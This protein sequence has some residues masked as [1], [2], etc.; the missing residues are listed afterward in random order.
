M[1]RLEGFISRNQ[2]LCLA[3]GLRG[4]ERDYFR[5]VID[6]LAGVI[7]A[8]PHSYQTDGQG[9]QA[10]AHLHYFTGG[11]DWWITEKDKGAEGDTPE[12]FQSQAFGLTDIGHGPELGYINIHELLSVNAE[13]DFHWTP[14]TLAEIKAKDQPDESPAEPQPRKENMTREPVPQVAVLTWA[15]E[16]VP[17]LEMVPERQW[18]WCVTN[19]Q[20]EAN[21]AARETIKAAGFKFAK[22]GH[23][24]PDG[25]IAYWAHSCDAPRK[26]I[27]KGSKSPRTSPLSP[28]TSAEQGTTY[29]NTAW[30]AVRREAMAFLGEAA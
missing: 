9:E 30:D 27:K 5:E 8:M 29:D 10:I 21:K 11:C 17:Q 28:Q 16:N 2:S 4:E 18:L 23:T 12:Q 20:G 15:E 6:K 14:K 7:E 19:L 3:D 24:L 26:F 25:R 13:L 1:K 22:K